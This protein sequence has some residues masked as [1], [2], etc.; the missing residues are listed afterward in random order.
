MHA[1]PLVT[2]IVPHVGGPILA[3][4]APT[5]LIGN[6]PAAR[7]SDTVTCVGPPD[8]IAK[9]SLTVLIMGL[10][11][12]RMGDTTVHGGS[13]V[14][15][16]P[17]VMIGDAPGAAGPTF[18]PGII[19]EGTPAEQAILAALLARI[20]DSGPNGAAFIA[21]LETAATPT[22]FNMATQSTDRHGNTVSLATTGGGITI[23]PTDSV[24]GDN[25]VYVDPTN[26]ITYGG[27]DGATHQERPE[28]LLA[29]EAGHAALLNAGDPAQT[30]GGAAAEANVRTLTNPIRTEMDM[31][32]EA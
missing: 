24:S 31:V 7:V 8:V 1:C 16:W 30:T 21:G 29:H 2:G 13:I 18:G 10:P 28:G 19:L 22:R 25:E 27:T 5:V 23:R 15:G 9:G 4:G 6:L 14:L 32:P 12:A 11:A 3:P 26:L 17:T 20:R